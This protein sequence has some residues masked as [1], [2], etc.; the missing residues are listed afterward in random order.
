MLA[1]ELN[2]VDSH[3]LLATIDQ[4]R[5]ILH[6]EKISLPHIVVV[7]DQSAGKSS[8]LEALS[9][10]QLPRGQ[11]ICTR[12]PLELRMKNTEADE[13]ATIR[14][15][16][17]EEMELNDFAEIPSQVLTCTNKLAGITRNAVGDQPENI[18]E[19]IIDL[20]THYIEK[21]TAIVLHVIPSSEDFTNS[22]S[23]KISKKYDPNGDRQLIAV[24]K[25]D[26]YDKGIGDKL[27]GIG[28]GS[29]ALRLGCVAVLNRT[30]EQIEKNVPFDKMRQLEQ[31][32]FQREKAFHGVREEYL[33][34]GQLIKRLVSIQQARIRSTLPDILD[35]L[36]KQIKQKKSELKNM[37]QAVTSEMECWTLYSSL[38]KKYRDLIYARVQGVYD[39]DMQ[40]SM[41]K[42]NKDSA[43][44][45]SGP[46]ITQATT[47]AFD[48]R[49]A[50]QLHKQ[51]KAFA[52][53]ISQS[54]SQFFTSKYRDYVLKLL[55]EN[56]GVA[57]SN[58]P[59]FSIIE[60]LYRHE[61]RNF[62][63][64]YMPNSTQQNVTVND[65]AINLSEVSNEH[66][67]ALDVQIAIKAYCRVVEKR[68]V[69]QGAQLCHFWFVDQCALKL[70]SKLSSTFTSAVLFQ[71]M[72]EPF[73][74]QQK[75][76]SLKRSIQS[77][78]K[79]LSTG[80]NA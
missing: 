9:G 11:H 30:P 55:E 48:D 44:S 46:D 20:V 1:E 28:P 71:L 15:D 27:Q 43:D 67:A 58:F 29:M 77:M 79:A 49:I 75:R 24:S 78:E 65:F 2:N 38:I 5:E 51:H 19:R 35:E 18:Y 12:C 56:A 50:F 3:R 57:L 42:P 32:F 14:C 80:Q 60:R 23:M 66:Q 47:D 72:C 26:K 63:E 61:H 59:S 36:K 53:D 13:Y 7:G 70:D 41:E 62:L 10:I 4:M 33:G 21:P 22:E 8:V 74:Q 39:D 31:Q 45:N 6:H 17:V 54:F 52:K 73:E 40:L 34:C 68:V 64:P 25:I 76:E 37:P 16:G 69:D